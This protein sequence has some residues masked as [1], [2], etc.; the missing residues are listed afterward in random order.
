MGV[1]PPLAEPAAL[2]AHDG[3]VAVALQQLDAGGLDLAPVSLYDHV[4]TLLGEQALGAAQ[5]L[6]LGAL[7]VDLHEARRRGELLGE[8]VQRAGVLRGVDDVRHVG[9]DETDR[10]AEL[11][12]AG[13]VAAD[14]LDRL[15]REVEG[16]RVSAG[17]P[18]E[19]HGV[20]AVVAAHVEA[21]APGARQAAQVA[22]DL[23]LGRAKVDVQRRLRV[24]LEPQPTAEPERDTSHGSRAQNLGPGRAL[25]TGPRSHRDQASAACSPGDGVAP[26]GD[27]AHAH[28][29]WHAGAVL[30]RLSRGVTIVAALTLLAPAT[31]SAFKPTGITAAPADPQAGANSNFTLHFDV[32]E[33]ARDLKGFVIHLPPGEVG[34]VTAT[35]LCTQAQFAAKACPANTQVGTTATH[36]TAY[37]TP[38]TGLAV[39]VPGKLYNLAPIGPEPARLG[40]RLTPDVGDEILLQSIV[41]VRPS[42]GG[43]DSSTDGLPRTSAI[44]PIDIN[45]VDITLFGK[46]GDPAKGFV[47]NPTSCAVATTTVDAIAYDGTQGSGSA[48][49]T[50]TGC[51]KLAFA[52]TISATLDPGAK[53]GRPTITTVVESPAGQAN[54]RS[55]QITL[56]AGLGAVVTT[57]NH[58]CPEAVFAQ[59]A[60]AA[61]AQIGSA[62]AETPALAAPLEGPV[63]LVKPDASPLPELIIDLHGPIDLRLPVTVGFGAGGRLQSTLDGLPDT[64]LSRFTLTLAGGPD[65]LLSNARDMCT[66]PIAHVDATFVGQNGASSSSSVIPQIAGCQPQVSAKL[67]GL[68]SRHPV[69]GAALQ[70]PAGPAA[71][72]GRREPPAHAA[73]RPPARAQGDHRARRRAQ[74]RAPD[75]APRTAPPSRWA[76]CRRAGRARSRSTSSAA[77]CASRG[78]CAPARP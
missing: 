53:G 3:L 17:E 1:G 33:P 75:A 14:A 11:A 54:A 48:A 42:D 12:V 47:S 28:A 68:R 9:L 30:S 2:L 41:T 32:E 56:P 45:A 26:A 71:D 76:G 34:A 60:C 73:R 72:L 22:G 23:D 39:N 13:E 29:I 57:L 78:A 19:G 66:A 59:G 65:S 67:K 52:P 21:H 58:A 49:F 15:G 64:A 62:R 44:G 61:N 5:H 37:P 4:G 50:P 38:I 24:G 8:A 27:G 20:T 31:A 43:L 16:H 77:H 10:S 25:Q 63:V 46:A 6:E 74:G 36:A 51:D 55:V 35:P 7:D 69:L 40:I 70:R 18:G